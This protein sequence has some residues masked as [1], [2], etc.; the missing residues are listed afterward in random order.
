MKAISLQFDHDW[1]Q[2]SAAAVGAPVR[3]VRRFD[4]LIIRNAGKIQM[5]S[6][7]SGNLQKS[8]HQGRGKAIGRPFSHVY[9]FGIFSFSHARVV[10]ESVAIL[11]L[12]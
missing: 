3:D 11:C 12:F 4:F 10:Q 7:T 8:R 5:S 1:M 9:V 6:H 2:T